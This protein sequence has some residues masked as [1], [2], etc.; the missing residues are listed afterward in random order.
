MADRLP[1]FWSLERF[2]DMFDMWELAERPSDARRTAVLLWLADRQED[3]YR[4]MRRSDE[5]PNQWH[6][7][8]PGTRE[9]D[10]TVVYCSYFIYDE[11]RRVKCDMLASLSPPFM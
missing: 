2:G 6:A 9:A 10:G 11:E 3:P 4:G 7:P 1:P 5:I 8:I